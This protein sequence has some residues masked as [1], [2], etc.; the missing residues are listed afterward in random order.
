MRQS[1]WGPEP[2]TRR[3]SSRPCEDGRVE[4]GPAMLDTR[5]RVGARR[6][7]GGRRG[8][9]AGAG[10]GDATRPKC[11]MNRHSEGYLLYCACLVVGGSAQVATSQ[12]GSAADWALSCC[13]NSG[14][15]PRARGI[16]W[17]TLRCRTRRPSCER[18]RCA[19]CPCLEFRFLKKRRWAAAPAEC[20]AHSTRG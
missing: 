11:A 16:Q 17:E 3:A 10:R 13:A 19:A 20:V 7:Q 9:G 4:D 5:S 18:C 2:A 14:T 12:A 1:N 15:A 8:E 6:W